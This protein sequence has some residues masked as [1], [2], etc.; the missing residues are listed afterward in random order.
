MT[1]PPL[2]EWCDAA[3]DAVFSDPQ[4]CAVRATKFE[5]RIRRRNLMEY[6]A[7]AIVIVGAGASS[8]AAGIK[9]DWG[10]ALAMALTAI[11]AIVVLWGLF[12]RATNLERRP[13][14]PC[15][16]HLR[17]Q[18]QRQYDA[19]RDVPLWYIGPLIPGVLTLYA[20]IV[21]GAAE[22]IG[23]IEALKGA[24]GPAVLTFGILAA[25]ALLNWL[26]A[27]S[28]KREIQSL[29]SLA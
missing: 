20:A 24:A 27:R 5:R 29:D 3:P 28:L 1:T 15:R 23:V 26:G 2:P 19:L 10:I 8:I 4:D 9:G 14:D 21:T 16:M 12:R 18:Y 25:V 17:R 22:Q 11:G 7:G 6:V 13:E